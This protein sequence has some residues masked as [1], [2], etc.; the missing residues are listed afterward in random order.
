[1]LR[2]WR[3]FFS[4]YGVKEVEKSADK[5]LW[6]DLSHYSMYFFST[7]EKGYCHH[8]CYVRIL[9]CSAKVRVE[10][11]TIV[12]TALV[13]CNYWKS[14]KFRLFKSIIQY[15]LTPSRPLH[16]PYLTLC[17]W[18]LRNSIPDPILMSPLC[19]MKM[20]S[21]VRLPWMMGGSHE[22]R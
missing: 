13:L 15:N 2:V 18:N 16:L 8:F 21:Q 1:M 3:L 22:W 4:R 5:L 19:W 14:L 6:L 11:A 9:D 20:V 10:T 12:Q 7:G 17:G